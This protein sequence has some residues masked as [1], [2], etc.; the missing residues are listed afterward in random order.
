[1]V[2]GPGTPGDPWTDD[3][4]CSFVRIRNPDPPPNTSPFSG[5][6]P[7]QADPPILRPSCDGPAAPAGPRRAPRPPRRSRR[8]HHQSRGPV[9]FCPRGFRPAQLCPR[10]HSQGAGG[11]I[12]GTIGTTLDSREGLHPTLAATSP[13]PLSRLFIHDLLASLPH[14]VPPFPRVPIPNQGL[15]FIRLSPHPSRGVFGNGEKPKAVPSYRLDE[16]L[17]KSSCVRPQ[18]TVE[19][20]GGGLF[21]GIDGEKWVPGV[22]KNGAGNQGRGKTMTANQPASQQPLASSAPGPPSVLFPAISPTRQR[23]HTPRGRS[24]RTCPTVRNLPCQG[25]EGGGRGCCEAEN[26]EET[27]PGGGGLFGQ[28]N[29]PLESPLKGSEP[30][31]FP[32]SI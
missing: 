18:A 31:P 6:P 11:S 13:H 2:G 5:P 17:P 29:S 24:E 25:A 7:P 3:H 15:S 9:I 14:L 4:R 28:S 21:G 12:P 10:L 27:P 16:I 19:S 8:S 1:M 22:E 23:W 32:P 30:V 20:E 26:S